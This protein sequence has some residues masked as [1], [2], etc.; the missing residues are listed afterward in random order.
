[1]P[2]T[3]P[4]SFGGPCFAKIGAL[5]IQFEDDCKLEMVP[6]VSVLSSALYG[7]YDEIPY[8]ML[9]KFSGTPR[10][11]DATTSNYLS[12]LF[13]YISGIATGAPFGGGN[14]TCQ[15]NSNNGDQFI[16]NNYLIGKMPGLRLG[17]DKGIMGGMEI[18]GCIQSGMDR[19]NAAAYYTFNPSGGAYT[20]AAP[21][22]PTTS[23]VGQQDFTATLGA[24]A[25]LSSF[26][27][28]E[29]WDIDHELELAP[30][31]IQGKTVAFRFQSY[32]ALAKCKPA[33]ATF[34]NILAAFGQQGTNATYGA[35][36]SLL[37]GA[38][39]AVSLALTGS[40]GTPVATLG[41]A[42][43]KSAGAAWGG[44]PLR[45]GEIAFI[46]SNKPGTSPVVPLTLA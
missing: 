26:Q 35:L 38:G 34:A 5:N 2:F 32:R 16:I 18:W 23:I 1:M 8:D 7:K 28:Q 44:K 30:V 6:V 3:V 29:A 22:V 20:Y 4:A 45:Q 31:V 42:G 13:P 9:L 19:N 21:A 25:G 39:A 41:N 14:A 24:V 17:I 10:Y 27:A 33:D 11:Y 46:S 37:A 15:I 12:T 40:S 43:L 36:T